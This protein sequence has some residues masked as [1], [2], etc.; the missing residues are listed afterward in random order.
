MHIKQPLKVL[1]LLLGTSLL[2][3]CY[4]GIFET[5]ELTPLGE[6][7]F[8]FG[9]GVV[10]FQDVATN[11]TPQIHTR[12]GISRNLDVG[13]R[14]GL[15]IGLGG[16]T[17][18]P[19]G[20]IADIKWGTLRLRYVGDFALGAGLG[21]AS[22]GLSLS[23]VLEFS[24]YNSRQWA[25]F[26]YA[27]STMRIGWFLSPGAVRLQGAGGLN[28]RFTKSFQT[29][30]EYSVAIGAGTLGSAYGVVFSLRF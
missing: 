15:S 6:W 10:M 11:V 28:I 5:A 18:T 16:G 21:V 8:K 29:Y 3:G 14:L 25:D 22:A 27:Y 26:L 1:I 20:L 12:Y 19:L 4:F 24:F 7:D 9:S 2:S 17:V 13:G 30:L 23:P